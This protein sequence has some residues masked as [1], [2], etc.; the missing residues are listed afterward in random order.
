ME[1]TSSAHRFR[2][3][4]AFSEEKLVYQDIV[5][6]GKC[7]YQFLVKINTQTGEATQLLDERV[8]NFWL[9]EDTI[10]YIE[11]GFRVFYIPE[12]YKTNPNVSIS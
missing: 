6:P 3:R 8:D 2:F 9:T 1:K 5:A 7:S 10:Y 11:R 12:D 4:G